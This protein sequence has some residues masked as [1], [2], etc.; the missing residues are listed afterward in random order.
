MA[1]VWEGECMGHSPGDEPD[2]DE[3]TQLYEAFEG[4]K[5]VLWPETTA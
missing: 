4:W 5:S 1:V 2:L 3:M